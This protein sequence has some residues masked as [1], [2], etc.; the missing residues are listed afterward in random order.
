MPGESRSQVWG[1]RTR[2]GYLI[3]V[4]GHGTMRESHAIQ[5]FAAG[6]LTDDTMTLSIDLNDAQFLDSTFLGCLIRLQKEFGQRQ[7]GSFRI[8]ATSEKVKAILMP[9]RVHTVLT[10]TDE[11]DEVLGECLAITSGV[12]DPKDLGSHIMECHRQLAEIEGPDQAAFRR[13]ADQLATEL[14]K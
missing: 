8:V 11:A 10:I 2:T 4:E 14:N 13:I 5:Q 3:R 6:A 7:P 1:G 9:S 12:S